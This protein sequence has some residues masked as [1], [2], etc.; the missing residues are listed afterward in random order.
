MKMILTLILM[1]ATVAGYTAEEKPKSKE[2]SVDQLKTWI[3]EN[4]KMIIV[5]SSSKEQFKGKMI[6]NSKQLPFDASEAT[7]Q[8]ALPAKDAWIIVYCDTADCPTSEQL[9][10]KLEAMGYTHVCV[11]KNGLQ[12]WIKKG[13]PTVN[14]KPQEPVKNP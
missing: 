10:K 5:D 7:I 6:P 9:T 8:E 3:D 11:I 1:L 4:F 13:F 2:V 12:D 14:K